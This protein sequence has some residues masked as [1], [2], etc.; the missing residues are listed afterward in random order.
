MKILPIVLLAVLAVTGTTVAM[1]G[2][3]LN[4]KR[5][6]AASVSTT[7]QPVELPPLAESGEPVLTLL[8][9]RGRFRFTISELEALGAHRVRTRSFWPSDEGVYEGP[10]LVDVLASAGLDQVERI[11]LMG[12]DCFETTIPRADWMRWKVLLAT[13]RDEAMLETASKGPL[14]IIYPRDSDSTLL[15]PVYRLRWIWMIEYIDEVSS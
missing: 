11:R 6:D 2:E 9:P 15:D 8:G 13:R 3:S 4:W 5:L 7:P 10:L 14:R 12:R 1:R